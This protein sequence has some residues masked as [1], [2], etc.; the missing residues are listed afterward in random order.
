M[1]PK[2][3]DDIIN[4]FPNGGERFNNDALFN[5]VIMSLYYGEDPLKI[6]DSLIKSNNEI[7]EAF[8]NHLLKK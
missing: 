7:S 4:E 3:I 2:S 6:I 1:S 8:R 5:T